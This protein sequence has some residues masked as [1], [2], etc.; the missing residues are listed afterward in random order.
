MYVLITGGVDRTPTSSPSTTP[1][2]S[3]SHLHRLLL[4]FDDGG[5]LQKRL[6]FVGAHFAAPMAG[7]AKVL[8]VT[9]VEHWQVLTAEQ[10]EIA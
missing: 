4:V 5:R 1:F 3:D 10:W 8:T 6:G 7:I 2:V 9:S